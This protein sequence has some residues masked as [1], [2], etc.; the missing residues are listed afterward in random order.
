MLWKIANIEMTFRL[1]LQTYTHNIVDSLH[2]T[3]NAI[4]TVW[5][6]EINEL[7]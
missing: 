7:H 3:M 2:E 5:K 1:Y 4:G 6:I